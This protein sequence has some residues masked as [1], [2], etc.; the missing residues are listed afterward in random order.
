MKLL[1]FLKNVGHNLLSI[2]KGIVIFALGAAMFGAGAWTLGW[3]ALE[4][5]VP[6]IQTKS[7]NNTYALGCSIF[8]IGALLTVLFLVARNLARWCVNTWHQS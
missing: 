6:E 7:G 5:G 2:L 4:A 3:L 1:R 8:L